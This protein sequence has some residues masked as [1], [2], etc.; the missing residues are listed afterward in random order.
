MSLR[1]T[2]VDLSSERRGNSN[3]TTLLATPFIRL[4]YVGFVE[5]KVKE[6]ENEPIRMAPH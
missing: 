3:N 5:R 2:D 4:D 6:S 1:L